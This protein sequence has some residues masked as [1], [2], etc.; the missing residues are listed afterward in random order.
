MEIILIAGCGNIGSRHLQSLRSV[1]Q[2]L[3]IYAYDPFQ[4]SLDKAK[5]IWDSTNGTNHEIHFTTS[6]ENI[7]AHIFLSIIA[8]NS[9][10]RLNVLKHIYEKHSIDHLILEKFLF[11]NTADYSIAQKIIDSKSTSV[12][13]NCPRRVFEP[14]L[15]F[16]N[17][18]DS[19]I[20]SI[21]LTGNNWGLC[22]N[23][24]HFLDLFNFI[25][26]KK[27]LKA[28]FNDKAKIMP[29]KREGYIEI[30]GSIHCEFEG[31]TSEI[32]CNEGDFSGIE[33][34]LET[35]DA[36]YHIEEKNNQIII[37]KNDTQLITGKIKFQSELTGTYVAKLLANLPLG[38][39]SYNES[40]QMHEVFLTSVQ[41]LTQQSNYNAPWKIS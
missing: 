4:P 16:K 28:K 40:R 1:E 10:E 18:L 33:I 27:P 7:P 21:K 31:F 2:A 17:E 8:T 32:N 20:K 34:H 41:E 11:P 29:S 39:T 38:L 35:M 19:P 23:T 3:T 30:F 6:L 12:H 9:S 24:I 22:S 15:Q 25:S 36:L 37:T 5:T 26:S 13:V 14:Y